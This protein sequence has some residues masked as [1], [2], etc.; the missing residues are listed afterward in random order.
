MTAT[1]DYDALD[2]S[3]LRELFDLRSNVYATRGGAFEDDP[4]PAFHRLRETGPVHEGIVG[5]L[6][7]Y[8]GEAFFQGLPYPDRTHVSCFDFATC[9]AV[10]R[11][12]ETFVAGDPIGDDMIDASILFMDGARHRRYRALVQPSFLPKRAAWW[13]QQ[14]IQRTVDALVSRLEGTGR[15][16]LNVEFFSAIPLL[17]I[18]GSFGISIAEALTIRAAVTSDGVG[19]GEF[20]R[21]VQPVVEARRTERRDDLISVLVEA[22]ITDEDGGHEAPDRCGDHLVRLPA[23]RGRIG[24]D[25]EADGHHHDRAPAATGAARG[26]PERSGDAEAGGRGVG[27]MD[28]DGP[29]VQSLRR[30]RHRVGGHR[31][32]DGL[33]RAPVPGC[34][35]PRSGAVGRSRPVRSRP[36]GAVAP[37]LRERCAHLPRHARRPGRDPRRGGRAGRATPE[38]PAGSRRPRRRGS[39]GC[40]SGAPTRCPSA[41]TDVSPSLASAH[42]VPPA[43]RAEPALA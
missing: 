30:P 42:S 28:T 8:H 6:V 10:F 14:W 3:R 7:G 13:Q 21:I 36:A 24:D 40:T 34:R 4:Y 25:L 43:R 19:I 29:H 41:S 11:D 26:G 5:E 23:A 31:R 20:L 17:T 2:R 16:D 15:A 33:G 22:E 12:G 32:A 35:Q 39:S 18:T 38:P 37:R 1:S 9:D 27:A